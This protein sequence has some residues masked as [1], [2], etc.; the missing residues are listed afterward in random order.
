MSIN[1]DRDELLALEHNRADLIATAENKRRQEKAAEATPI[2][3][4]R[5]TVSGS[6]SVTIKNGSMSTASGGQSTKAQLQAPLPDGMVRLSNSMVTTVEAAQAAGFNVATQSNAAST[7]NNGLPDAHQA[8][9]ENTSGQNVDASLEE[10]TPE[11]IS[12]IKIAHAVLD[13][14]NKTVGAIAVQSLQENTVVSGELPRHL[15][16][17]VTTE[18]VNSLVDGYTAQAN[19]ALRPTGASV[20]GLIA[21]LTENELREARLA[22]YRGDDG[23][24]R[25]LGGK[26]QD[27]L[28]RLPNDPV[29]FTELTADL[30]KDVQ[31]SRRGETVWVKAPE[32][33]REMQWGA[34]V[35]A[36]KIRL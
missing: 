5:T 8:V 13:Q 12:K 34:A 11:E 7:F 16:E 17:G 14:G 15:P 29:H 23:K 4:M 36:G 22:T 6:A 28:A 10:A 25:E 20:H 35:R 27:R 1:E 33:P 19:A 2:E 30:P 24:L 3:M 9:P 32:W 26:A 31:L 18:Q 21:L